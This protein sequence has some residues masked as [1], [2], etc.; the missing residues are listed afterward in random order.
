MSREFYK[1]RPVEIK[2]ERFIMAVVPGSKSITNRALLLAAM[3]EGES[4]IKN[5][6]SSEDAAVF[7][8]ALK[9]LGF[10][11]R[12]SDAPGSAIVKNKDITI[13]G[14]GG[15]IPVKKAD[16][17]VGSAGTA[18][19]FLLAMLAFSDGEYFIDSSDQMKARPMEPLIKALTGAGAIV[20]CT[21]E[22]GHFPLRV[23][24]NAGVFP[25]RISVNIEKSSQFLSALL[26][27]A[28]A[29]GKKVIISA[30]GSHGLAYV[31]MSASMIKDFGVNV[32]SGLFG[33]QYDPFRGW[34]F[35]G[36]EKL[37]GREYMVE[38]DMSAAA[39]F[40]AAAAILGC[41]AL[42]PGVR[43]NML[44]G[45]TEF[46]KL[47]EKMG[48]TL[49]EGEEGVVLT[50]PEGG[51]LKSPGIVDMGA[52]S[53]Q[54]LTLAAL[55]PFVNG[56]AAIKGIAHIRLQE[57]DRI[58]AIVK[59]LTAL[60]ETC[61]E[62]EDGVIMRPGELH[63]AELESF[64]DHRVAMAFALCGL[65]IDGVTIKDPDCCRKTF[66]EYFEVLEDAVNGD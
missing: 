30:S 21:E 54:A 52:Y 40:Y 3:A 46:L 34:Q 13:K 43:L 48:C 26:I 59:N 11:I 8:Q 60:G 19:R 45:D 36:G 65:R 14:C 22:E 28:A 58:A 9:D 35:E 56:A 41:K 50:G 12:E 15:D 31:E 4:I 5:C 44:Q 2:P 7:L 27:A 64:G 6:M 66:A 49:C 47:L 61:E 10:E 37:K 53:D 25:E 57:C 32:K 1:V 38:P 23:K 18:A 55:A 51:E 63:G 24:G 39:Y 17:Y 29:Y 62:R 20:E 33:S 16:I 42:V